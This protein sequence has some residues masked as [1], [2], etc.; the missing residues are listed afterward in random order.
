MQL[1]GYDTDISMAPPPQ[2]L[3]SSMTI[4]NVDSYESTV[5]DNLLGM[6]DIVHVTNLGAAI[7]DN[8]PGNVVK[9]AMAMLS[10]CHR[11]LGFPLIS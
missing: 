6:Y 10:M 8:N 11:Y 1:D 2:W 9:N 5:P 7:K 4:K 3:P